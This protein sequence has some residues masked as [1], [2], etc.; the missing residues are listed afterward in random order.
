[1]SIAPAGCQI[2][3][4][5]MSRNIKYPRRFLVIACAASVAAASL[6]SN[7]AQ[8]VP[9][10]AP[11]DNLQNQITLLGQQVSQTTLDLTALQNQM[12]QSTG[13]V[14]ALTSQV[15]ALQT[16]VNNLGQQL[17][18]TT[19]QL[20]T[21]SALANQTASDVTS[22]GGQMNSLVSQTAALSA[23]V[24][25]LANDIASIHSAIDG[26][27]SH[28]LH[29][30]TS[31][32]T[33]H[34]TLDGQYRPDDAGCQA[35]Y[36]CSSWQEITGGDLKYFTLTERTKLLFAFTGN[37]NWDGYV[38][39]VAGSVF[40][41][42]EIQ[43]GSAANPLP[44]LQRPPVWASSNRW[45][46]NSGTDVVYRVVRQLDPGQYVV[47]VKHRYQSHPADGGGFTNWVLFNGALSI[48][49]VE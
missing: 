34:M 12:T 45:V 8:P 19:S 3:E 38:S 46:P 44:P 6:A 37:Y 33:L 7:A 11:F 30:A 13:T 49:A 43:I 4:V 41:S 48:D 25:T 14:S 40:A 20:S 1:M 16:Q 36:L 9:P 32:P 26:L 22:L 21:V 10:G 17:T 31:F 23:R 42:T 15:N 35:G 2:A 28:S 27:Q 47:R 39:G 18:Q 5:A 24:D 29:L